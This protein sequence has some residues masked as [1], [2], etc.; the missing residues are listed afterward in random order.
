LRIKPKPLHFFLL[1]LWLI[2][3][4]LA[5]IGGAIASN[6]RIRDRA[7]IIFNKATGELDGIGWF[8]LLQE[9]KPGTTVD[10][11]RLAFESNLFEAIRNPR[12]SRSDVEAGEQLFDQ[13]CALCHGD[14][15]LGGLGGPSL[16]NHIFRNGQ[17]DLALYRTI[18]LGIP[19]TPMVPQNLSRDDVW[20]LVSYLN[21]VLILTH[22]PSP[23]VSTWSGKPFQPVTA[24]ELRGAHDLHDE[25]LTY[26]GSYSSHRHSRLDQINPDNVRHLRVEWER[27][28]YLQDEGRGLE[29]SPIVRGSTMFITQ[30]NR[31]LALDAV[32]G[33]VIWTYSRNLP[34]SALCC[35]GYSHNRGVALLGRQVFVG[36]LDAHLIALDATR[37]TVNWDVAIAERGSITGAPLAID[38]IVITGVGGGDYG[39]SGF[40]EARDAASGKRR[41]RFNT[42][43]KVGEL[44]SETW[45]GH[46]GAGSATWLTGSF[47][48][49]LRL[50]YWGVGNP[51]PGLNGDA[52]RPGDNLYSDSIVALD[53]DTGKLRWYF[54]FTPHDLHD[55]DGN[56]IPVLVDATVDDVKRKL[57]ATANR[58]GFYYLLDR[59]KGTFL[60]GTPF[61]RQTWA[62]GL[63][64]TGRPRVRPESK[65]TLK[66]TFVYPGIFGGTNWWSPTFDPQLDLL[67]VPTID[68]GSYFFTSPY[69]LG[70]GHYSNVQ[71]NL[72]AAVKAIEVTTGRIRWQHGLPERAN[73]PVVGGLLSTAGR[74]IFGGDNET[75]F[76]LNAETGA[77]L[78]HFEVGGFIT[79]APVSYEVAGR[80]YVAIA[81][82]HN[83]LVFALPPSDADNNNTTA[84]IVR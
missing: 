63:D 5:V 78:W 84:G 17:S 71:E 29:S 81:A 64:A 3:V 57:L 53:A 22:P 11:E 76:A 73:T 58:N 20:R 47:D 45:G 9:L 67:F 51:S 61:V 8:D 72:N 79:A 10:V 68:Q 1:G 30:D 33:H 12:H 80:Q 38:D 14:R 74:I 44:G 60:L 65:P 15:A 83:I 52:V 31:V 4:L 49:E 55:W 77:E 82:A 23:S 21:S 34:Q 6:N 70:G 48:P 7:I 25:W 42:A 54:Q 24:S 36:T 62:D 39:V 13:H 28:L 35:S 43:P 2:S 66:G 41:W 18:M 19:G 75:F 27:Q 56:Q 69:R 16:Q 40:I 50:I 37:G 59:T 26:S 46:D 32:T